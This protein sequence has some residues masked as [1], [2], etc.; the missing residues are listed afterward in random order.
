[1]RFCRRQLGLTLLLTKYLLV[2]HCISFAQQQVAFQYIYDQNQQL[3][4]VIDSMGTV[5]T[6][7]YDAAG[8]I[9]SVTQSTTADLG[10]PMITNVV[11]TVVHHEEI[12]EVVISGTNFFLGT[13]TIDVPEISI[14]NSLITDNEVRI[15]FNTSSAA[16]LGFATITIET[17]LGMTTTTVGVKGPLP[18]IGF[19][20]PSNGTAFGGTL[21]TF[22]GNRFT[23]DSMVTFS[24]NA[25]TNVTFVSEQVLT[26]RTPPGSPGFSDVVV[27]N[28]NGSARTAVDFLYEF[29]FR[30]PGAVP[31]TLDSLATTTFPI[32]L[33]EPATGILRVS[34]TNADSS[35]ATVPSSAAF[36]AN[37][38]VVD[39]PITGLAEGNSIV[40]VTIGS[41]TLSTAIF[42]P[43]PA[44]VADILGN[45]EGQIA[46]DAVGLGLPV[47]NPVGTFFTPIEEIRAAPIGNFVT[48]IG[49]ETRAPVVGILIAPS[50]VP[51]VEVTSGTVRMVTIQLVN[52]APAGGL[53][54]TLSS[55]NDNITTVPA[56]VVINEGENIVSF[57][58]TAVALGNALILIS[59]GNESPTLNVFVDQ[60]PTFVG[61]IRSHTVAAFITPTTGETISPIVSLFIP[62][63][64]GIILAPTVG[65][66]IGGSG[67]GGSDCSTP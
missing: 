7:N 34:L 56:Q 8:N 58:I 29:P 46:A 59:A 66:C 62:P 4:R 12:E 20:N 25:A 53:T 18:R 63:V 26:V 60:P 39:I 11:P 48:P 30:L 36:V 31:V 17:N 15:L 57:D 52:A 41:F 28:V 24:G 55:T 10:P 51:S 37:D 3:V 47:A 64:T 54:V 23:A 50:P 38:Q 27:T 33:I 44:I 14:I 61:A 42:V 1:M 45:I 16:P 67:P 6:Y 2:F 65:L 35:I 40:S 21:V 5:I 32:T 49:G 43:D 22:S 9:I 13:V 19:M